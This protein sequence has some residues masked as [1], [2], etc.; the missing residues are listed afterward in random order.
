MEGLCRC[1][2]IVAMRSGG[3]NSGTFALMKCSRLVRSG[4]VALAAAL[5]GLVLMITIIDVVGLVDHA[6]PA[7]VIVVLGSQV[8]PGGRVSPSLERRAQ[9][10]AA[11]YRRGLAGHILC[12]GG[13]G[14]NPPSE[15]EVACGRIVEL[16]V[17]PEVMV[18]EDRSHSTEENAADSAAILRER[19]WRSAILVTDGFHMLRAALMFERAGITVYPSPAQVTAG[20]MNPIERIGREARET[21][22]L[23]WFGVRLMLGIDLTRR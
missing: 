7:D 21:V 19:G 17:P 20:P 2:A 6:Q 12:S 18:R 11:L 3:V 15:A 14:D 23:V 9:H 16:G 22:G 10:A 8:Y 13:V 1:G 5:I 4:L